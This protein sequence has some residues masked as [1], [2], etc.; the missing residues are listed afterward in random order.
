[1]GKNEDYEW[2]RSV[3]VKAKEQ[4]D[5]LRK[6]D[7]DAVVKSGTLKR[8]GRTSWYEF[9]GNVGQLPPAIGILGE[10]MEITKSGRTRIKLANRDRMLRVLEKIAAQEV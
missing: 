5:I 1:M 4:R 7:L 8:V 6:F 2:V 10:G 9:G 3:I